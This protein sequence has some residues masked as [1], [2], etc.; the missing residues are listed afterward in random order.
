[1]K[2]WRTVAKKKIGAGSFVTQHF[3]TGE[4]EDVINFT[5]SAA[6]K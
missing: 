4:D 2:N 1:M 6:A 5:H 3:M